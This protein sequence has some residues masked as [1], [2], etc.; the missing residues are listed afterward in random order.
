MK[1]SVKRN[2]CNITNVNELHATIQVSY[3]HQ[4]KCILCAICIT[5]NML[6]DGLYNKCAWITFCKITF[7]KIMSE[8]SL[9]RNENYTMTSI[10]C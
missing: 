1:T 5:M 2:T 4:T 9:S 6:I 8:I 10:D 3:M 7:C